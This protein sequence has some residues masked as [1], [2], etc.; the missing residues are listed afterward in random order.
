MEQNDRELPIAT[1]ENLMKEVEDHKAK[2][3]E[4]LQRIERQNIYINKLN[5]KLNKTPNNERER[6]SEKQS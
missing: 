6:R 3:K 2:Y 5:E 4:A 1:D